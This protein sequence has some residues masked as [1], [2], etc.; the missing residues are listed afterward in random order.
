[1]CLL[2]KNIYH[3]ILKNS[4]KKTFKKAGIFTY[5]SSTFFLSFDQ[6]HLFYFLE[7]VTVNS[8]YRRSHMFDPTKY[9][10]CYRQ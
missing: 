4:F 5:I 7:N 2:N 6:F 3:K 10:I 8:K 1:M 9:I